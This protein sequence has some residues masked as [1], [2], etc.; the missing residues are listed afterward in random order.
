MVTDLRFFNQEII[1]L[2]PLQRIASRRVTLCLPPP[3]PAR[4][5]S[6]SNR[7]Y[8]DVGIA[9]TPQRLSTANTPQRLQVD[10]R[11][12][13]APNPRPPQA[14]PQAIP[15]AMP[16]CTS[17]ALSTARRTA[18]AQQLLWIVF[19]ALA[20]TGSHPV[21]LPHRYHATAPSALLS[22]TATVTSAIG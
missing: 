17:T 9:N 16:R 4:A 3:S 7:F 5:S 15:Q 12:S 11:P 18:Y 6:I 21:R 22:S 19:L 20:A 13:L 1:G 8:G 10:P 2:N 14:V